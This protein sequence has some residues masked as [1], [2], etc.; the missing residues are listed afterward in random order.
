MEVETNMKIE[1][2]E[3]WVIESIVCVFQSWKSKADVYRGKG[4]FQSIHV[5]DI[6]RF[7]LIDGNSGILVYRFGSW[8][9]TLALGGWKILHVSW[10]E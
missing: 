8:M 5:N 10:W 9:T 6:C 7:Q 1:R 2:V 3:F 4:P